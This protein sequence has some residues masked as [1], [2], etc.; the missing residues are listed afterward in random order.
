[1]DHVALRTGVLVA[2][3][4]GG[5]RTVDLVVFK[6]GNARGA[7]D[8]AD[9][10]DGGGAGTDGGS[11]GSGGDGGA[12]GDED[13]GADGA[14]TDGGDG[15]GDGGDDGG[16]PPESDCD[17]GVDNDEDGAPDCS[18]DDCADVAPCWWPDA[19]QHEGSFVFRG[20]RVT[21]ETWLGDF[22]EQV[23]NC[24][25]RYTSTLT[26]VAS[27]GCPTCDRTYAGTLSYSTNTCASVVGGTY[28]ATAEIGFVFLS[29]TSWEV[30][31]AD[32]SGG[33]TG[34]GLIYSGGRFGFETAEPLYVDTGDCDNDPLNAG[35]LTVTW[36]FWE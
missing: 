30:Y 22:D 29:P 25:T 13:G 21:C 26:P 3:L 1:M 11:G 4:L 33:W 31:G 24:E 16:L 27:G 18:D 7:Q 5:C 35:T 10:G 34:T 28:P 9:G 23:D 36:Q 15:A 6:K 17:D 32:E 8:T 20:N 14:G 19:M 2:I 12:D